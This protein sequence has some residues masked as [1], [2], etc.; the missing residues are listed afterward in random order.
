MLSSPSIIYHTVC[1]FLD[2]GLLI[3]TKYSSFS[4]KF[5]KRASVVN[6]NEAAVIKCLGVT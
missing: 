6:I 2:E 3:P 4:D 1:I 5:S